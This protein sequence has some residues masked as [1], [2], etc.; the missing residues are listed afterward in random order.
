MPK[1]YE[2]I[3]DYYYKKYRSLGLPNPLKR[4]KQTAARIFIS[5]WP[6]RAKELQDWRKKKK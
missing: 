5:R 4:A 1:V 2:E 3:R 6:H